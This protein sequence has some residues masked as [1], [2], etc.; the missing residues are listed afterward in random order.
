MIEVFD[1]SRIIEIRIIVAD[2]K[3]I[4][5]NEL[6]NFGENIKDYIYDLEDSSIEDVTYEIKN[7]YQH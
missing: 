7:D 6:S 4:T 5:E 3:T 1:M 2:E